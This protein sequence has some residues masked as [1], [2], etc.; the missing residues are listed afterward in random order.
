M[1]S[2][3]S[4][5]GGYKESQSFGEEVLTALPFATL[6]SSSDIQSD[7]MDLLDT[8]LCLLALLETLLISPESPFSVLKLPLSLK[9]NLL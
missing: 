1:V 7:L 4:V 6:D 5:K 2:K 8:R 3:R 9:L